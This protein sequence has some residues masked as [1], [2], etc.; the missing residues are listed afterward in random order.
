MRY[1][2]TS[3]LVPLFLPEEASERIQRWFE[4]QGA[5]GLAISDWTLS[6]F[7]SALGLKVRAKA[8]KAAQAQMAEDLLA[9]LATD[10]LQVLTPGRTD[11]ACAGTFLRQYALGLR[12]GDAL[13]LAIAH[14]A[15]AE[16]VYS[17]DKKFVAAG[18]RLK[19]RTRSPI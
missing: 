10:S 9:R 8:L 16:A 13:H 4:A 15:G 18:R 14:N 5:E 3:V 7:S 19:I 1:L 12:A 2:D 11:Y 17:L 6:E